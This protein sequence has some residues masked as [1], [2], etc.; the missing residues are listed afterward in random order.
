MRH[1]ELKRWRFPP[2]ASVVQGP[3]RCVPGR[4]SASA[5]RWF[6]GVRRLGLTAQPDINLAGGQ[7]AGHVRRHDARTGV[8]AFGGA[9]VLLSTDGIILQLPPHSSML[10]NIAGP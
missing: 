9:A 6:G 1:R 2:L 5:A 10:V 4:L 7:E 8:A 3:L